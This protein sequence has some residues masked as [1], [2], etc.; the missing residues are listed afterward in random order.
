M[1]IQNYFNTLQQ[2][3]LFNINI[4]ADQIAM[5][6]IYIPILRTEIQSYVR[7]WNGHRIRK[8]PNRP[9]AVAGKPHIL[10][11]YPPQ[12]VQNYGL[13]VDT[14]RLDMLQNDVREWGKI[15]LFYTRFIK[16]NL[17]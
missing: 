6:A 12:L 17:L 7:T 8:Q 14:V 15:I 16:T 2:D 9:N 3:G 11:H 13:S 4:K 5:F 1:S 10:Y